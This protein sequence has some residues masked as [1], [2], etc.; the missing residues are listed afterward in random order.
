MLIEFWE[1][2][3]GYNKWVDAT[4]TIKSSKLNE[5]VVGHDRA[6]RAFYGWFGDEWLTWKDSSGVEQSEPMTVSE[7][8]PVFQCIEGNTIVVRYNPA[9]PSEFYIREQLKYQLNRAVKIILWISVVIA[10]V[11]ALSF[12]L[13]RD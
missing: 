1:K 2:F 3:R 11:V 12:A 9:D 6:G 8:S 5:Q 13:F 7:D 4:A 10:A